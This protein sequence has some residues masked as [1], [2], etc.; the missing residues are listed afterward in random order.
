VIEKL[1]HFRLAKVISAN[2]TIPDEQFGFRPK[3][4]TTDQLLRV[5][6]YASVGFER[7]HVTGVVFLDVAKAF[8]TVW[9]DELVFKLRESNVPLAMTQLIQSFL[10][11]HSFRAKIN[12]TLSEPHPI[13]AGVPQGSVLSPLLYAAF[14]ADIPKT[15]NTTLAMYA[16]DTAIMTRSKQPRLATVHLQEAANALETW[17]RRW[18]IEVNPE[19]SSALLITR[20]YVAR[21]GQVRMFGED[22]PWKG[23]VKY[24]GVVID[25]RLAF[26]PHVNYAVGK[27][28]MVTGQLSPLTCRRSKMSIKNKLV[29]YKSVVLPTMTYA[30]AAWGHV[31]DAQL[32]KLQVIQN[33]FLRRTFNAPWFVRND[34]LH[35]EAKV[36]MLKELLLEIAQRTFEKVKEHENPLVREAVDYDEAGPSRCKRPKTVLNG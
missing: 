4:S 11:K 17:F 16:D 30:S 18:R 25:K 21:E 19:K 35:R 34:Q 28:K 33:Q 5:T 31:S 3:H 7:K 22:I 15:R 10:E 8:D 12:D 9:H 23:Q 13:E 20:R 27:G 26:I 24:L 36:P 32:H 14:T 1:I 6:E 2:H 29:L